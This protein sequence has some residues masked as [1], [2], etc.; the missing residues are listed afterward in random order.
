MVTHCLQG[1]GLLPFDIQNQP[2]VNHRR[3]FRG[4]FVVRCVI[5]GALVSP[6]MMAQVSGGAFRGEV[7]DASNAIVPQAKIL[8][9]S[10]DSG[11]T[12]IEETNGGGLYNSA[13]LLPGSY[14]LTATKAGFEETVAGPVVVNVSQIVRVDFLLAVGASTQSV[15][16]EATGAQLLSPESADISQVIVSKQVSEIPLN[17]RAWQQLIRL[18]A[19]VSAG[20]PGE[21]GSPNPVDVNGQRSKSNLYLVDGIS[22][23]SSAQ[24]RGDSF[25]IPLEA[26]REFS[27]QAGAYPAEFGDVAGGVIN[28]QSKSG[29]NEW[30]GSLFEFLRNDAFDAADFFA[31]ATRQP[32]NPLRYNQFGGAIGGPV[33][34]D[35]TFVFA[36]YQGTITHSATPMITT[37]PTAAERQGDFSGLVNPNGAIVPIYNPFGA[38]I[39]RAPFAGNLIPASL[40]DPAAAAITSLLP[41]PNQFGSG[42]PLSFNNYAATPLATANFQ[43]FDLRVDHQFSPG[44][45]VF[46]RYSFQHTDAVSPSIFGEPLGGTI[47]GA[48]PTSAGVQNAGIGHFWQINPLFSNELRVGLNR[49]TTALT[50]SDYGR[51]SA[52]QFGIPG[53]NLSP[54]TSGLPAMAV[55]GLFNVGDSLLTP[56]YLASTDWNISE[57]VVGIKGRH[58]LRFGLDYQ[59]ELGST[60][61]LVYGRGFY[62]YLN[63]TTSSAVGTPGGNAFASFLTGAPYQVLRDTFPAGLIGLISWRVGFYAQDDIKLTPTLTVNIGARY[64]IMP[65]PRE[66]HNR[67]SN[68]DPATRTMLLA[69]VNTNPNLV[70]TDYHDLAPR[71]GLAW[72]PG[73]GSTV[74]RAGYGIGYVDPL[75]GEGALNSNEFNLPFYYL[76]NVT[77]FPFTQQLYTLS[78]GLPAL[79]IPSPGAPSGNQ[80][81]IDPTERNAYSQSWSLGI[82]RAI[83]RSL[84]AEIDYV[85]TSGVGLLTATNINAALP[86]ATNPV[87]R[88]PYGPALSE[89]RELSDSAHSIYHGLQTKIEQ[90]LARGLYFLGSYTWSKA[91][92]NQSNG[93]DMAIASGQYPQ[94]PWNA[95]LDRGLSSFD[96]AQRFVASFVWKLP[97][98]RGG[99]LGRNFPGPVD[100][101]IT[102]WQISGVLTAQS[103]SPFSVL[104]SCAD[105]NAEGNNCRPNRIASG[106]SGARG[107]AIAEWFNTSAFRIP[108]TPAYGNAGRNILFG[109]GMQNLDLGFS[110]SFRWNDNEV[111]RIQIRG[112]FF[113]SLNHTN[114]ALPVNSI[115]SPSFGSI[116]TAAPG[117]EIQLGARVEF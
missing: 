35:R 101:V 63:L 72:T 107:Q 16:V 116:I 74:V 62:T 75:G 108:A 46:A 70:N 104:M 109:P 85:G 64:D 95:H 4:D 10:L 56:L 96:V 66:M 98:G 71:I 7:R 33:R 93:T 14:T 32:R 111:R 100:S 34:H 37:V 18:S 40:I 42:G 115:D 19:G 103:G 61:Y 53:V 105:I 84:M 39:A 59:H 77:Q 86:G 15:Q 110:R 97:F 82:Q 57:K 2:G 27:V 28:L 117:R 91:I 102:G 43:A 69:G 94:D 52:Q 31:N 65:Y 45:T 38:S 106:G 87:P 36:D 3:R 30:H 48:G 17:S 5:L 51:N 9:R 83:T 1:K 79:V 78:K 25:N 22:T 81:Y 23:T 90:R 76:N 6:A 99:A 49:Q 60:G 20:A 88:Q 89:I 29:T 12:V 67:L 73:G 112:E 8:I 44:N 47:L 68:F 114:F 54:Q 21:S 26:V 50:Q 58:I 92:D 24:G 55:A 13:N 41:L 11:T 113:N 80:R